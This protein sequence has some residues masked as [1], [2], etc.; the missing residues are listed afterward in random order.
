MAD[1]GVADDLGEACLAHGKGDATKAAY[2][3]ADMIA[4]RRK[5]MQNW[6]AFLG[7]GEEHQP[8]NVIPLAARRGEHRQAATT[9]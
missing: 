2:N 9:S 8:D 4:L 1:H 7:G 5:V 3:R 6:G